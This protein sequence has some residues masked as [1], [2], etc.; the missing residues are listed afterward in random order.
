MDDK[1]ILLVEDNAD[2]EKLALLALKKSNIRNE[3]V[4]ARDGVEAL[5][6]LFCR[7]PYLG[8][9]VNIM[10]QVVLLDLKLPK[11]DGL[12]VLRRLRADQRTKLLPVVITHYMDEAEYCHRV[13]LMYA[14]RVVAL[15]S[16]AELKQSLGSGNLLNLESSDL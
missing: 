7:G 1:I 13:A 16:P 14:G 12:E 8:R 11:L 2:D 4:V 9:D 15:G 10:P 6:Y 3:V 5:N